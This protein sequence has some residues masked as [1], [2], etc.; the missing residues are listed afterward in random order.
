MSK[1]RLLILLVAIFAGGAAFFLVES[2][3]DD[4]APVIAAVPKQEGPKMTRVLI[5][6]D[7]VAQGAVLTEDMTSWIKYPERDVPSFY[8]TEDNKEFVKALPEM[9]ARRRLHANEPIMASNTVRHGQRGMLAS[10]MTEGMRAVTV[11]VSAAQTSGGFVLPG[12]RVDVFATGV[13]PNDPENATGTWLVFSN[14]RVLAVDQ[15]ANPTDETSA[16]VGRT[17][18]LEMPPH[19]VQSFLQTRARH[20]VTLVLRSLFETDMPQPVDQTTPDQVVVIRYGQG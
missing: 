8:V 3:E 4:A 12:D 6:K 19:Q 16:I 5:A 17:V 13:D 20:S 2:S 18:T 11:G 14:I 15:V 9:R 7:D 1:S 10:I